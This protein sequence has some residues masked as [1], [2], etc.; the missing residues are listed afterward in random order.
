M[1]ISIANLLTQFMCL[2][3]FDIYQGAV[4]QNCVKSLDFLGFF[5]FFNCLMSGLKFTFFKLTSF[6]SDNLSGLK[7]YQACIVH[8]SLQG[9]LYTEN[10][11]V[12][13]LNNC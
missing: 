8:Q 4:A 13:F 6:I 10:F 3:T 9:G 12:Y 7:K 5:F 11:E 1:K 2:N